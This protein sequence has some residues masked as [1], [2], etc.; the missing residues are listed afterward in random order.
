M[1]L[2]LCIVLGLLLIIF[3]L[4]LIL[5]KS[6]I[7]RLNVKLEAIIEADTNSHLTITTLD[8]GIS[9]FTKTINNMLTCNRQKHFEKISIETD[10]KRAITNISHDLR[11]PLTSALGYLQMLKTA[12]HDDETRQRYLEI[13]HERLNI[14]STLMS[15]L[16]EFAR[17]I[18][19]D[20]VLDFQ[21][22]NACNVICDVLS[23]SYTELEGKGFEV[24]VDT[25]DAPIMY[26]CDPNALGR[27]FQ[28]LIENAYT[29]GRKYLQIRFDN[30]AIEIANKVD[31][32]SEI[33]TVRLFD[34]FY[35][36][37]ASRS[38]KRTG[39]GL[40]IAKGLVERMNGNISAR[41]E[42]DILV[43]CVVL[44]KG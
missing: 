9:A 11:T 7:R 4:R 33:D 5:I 29:H 3:L 35:T 38:N 13:I 30:D 16:F 27:I 17:V 43:I 36:S 12:E 39:L 41:V 14:L 24:D 18:E 25:P 10:L 22:A 37:D 23:A 6:E 20:D 34:R 19:G 32:P 2:A 21:K 31:K 15:S 44:P 1:L 28:N 40:A 8:K 42:G 26:I